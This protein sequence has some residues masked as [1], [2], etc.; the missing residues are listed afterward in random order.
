[1][2]DIVETKNVRLKMFDLTMEEAMK[3]VNDGKGLFIDVREEFEVEAGHIEGTLWVPLMGLVNNS[4]HFLKKI[5]DQYGDKELYIYCRA[6]N[7]SGVASQ[8]LMGQGAT[9][10]NV[11]GLNEV[12]EYNMP[13][14]T[15]TPKTL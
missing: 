7:R 15:G 9:A 8:A 6:G 14:K 13:V 5:K 2:I 4:E 12:A 11:G 1:M 3:R 10:Y